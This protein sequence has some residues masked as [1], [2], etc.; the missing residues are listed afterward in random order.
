MP[1]RF[2]VDLAKVLDVFEGDGVFAKA[3]VFGIYRA[4]TRQEQQRIQQ[5]GRVSIGENKTVAVRP[6]RIFRVVAQELLPER[7]GY[8]G[9]RHR[10]AWMA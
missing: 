1:R 6:D 5:H 2:A 7:V 4:H 3:L 8:R 9:Q 10:S